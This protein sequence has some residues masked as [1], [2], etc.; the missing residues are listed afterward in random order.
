MALRGGFHYSAKRW[1]DQ[2]I[3]LTGIWLIVSPWVFNYPVSSPP[4]INATITG[5]ILAV[6]AAF[7]L[8]KTYVW[9]VLLNV[10][11]G[12]WVAV[13]PWLLDII[14]DRTMTTSLLVSGLAT[15]VLGLWELRSDPELHSQWT[16]SG[17]T[18]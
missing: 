7:D 4:A 6:L 14:P 9:A 1:Q 3:L 13:S 5:I 2:V 16:K 17:A 18:G 10:V 8:Y 12:A 11:A 15:V